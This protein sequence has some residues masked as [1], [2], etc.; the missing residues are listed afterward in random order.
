MTLLGQRFSWKTRITDFRP[1]EGF[2]DEAVD[3]PL[4]KWVH[5]HRF[6]RKDGGTVVED[7]IRLSTN[8]GPLMDAFAKLVIARIFEF[9]NQAL[10]RHFGEQ[11]TPVYRDPL[12]IGLA[13]G[14][15]LLLLGLAVGSFLAM[16][17]PVRDGLSTSVLGFVVGLVGW[18]L[19]WFASHDLAHLIV[20][21]VAGVRFSHYYVGLSNAVRL[22]RLIPESLRL[23]ALAFGIRIDRGRSKAGRRGFAAMYLAGPLASMLTPFIVPASMLLRNS[24]SLAGLLILAISLS[25][26]VLTLYFSRKAGCLLKASRALASVAK[27]NK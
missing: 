7:D 17:A 14:S 5:Q 18:G 3:S 24:G 10:R 19:F 12:R 21:W 27:V 13:P 26:L 8:L 1:G 2:T 4:K 6:M 25:N 20:G 15:L 23:A 22:K 9:R 11:V 16:I